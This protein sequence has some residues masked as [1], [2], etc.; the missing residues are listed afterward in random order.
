M[1]CLLYLRSKKYQ[2]SPI[3]YEKINLTPGGTEAGERGIVRA[4]DSPF[5]SVW[6]ESSTY[7]AVSFTLLVFLV[8]YRLLD[9]RY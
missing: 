9:F 2:V 8:I 3:R 4:E 6:E 1:S 5:D 7:K